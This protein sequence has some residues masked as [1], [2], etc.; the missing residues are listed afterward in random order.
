[1]IDFYEYYGEKSENQ[2]KVFHI[3]YRLVL[4]KDLKKGFVF[5]RQKHEVESSKFCARCLETS[6]PDYEKTIEPWAFFF[7]IFSF[8]SNPHESMRFCEVVDN[9]EDLATSFSKLVR[10][11]LA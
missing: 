8:S 9:E 7:N 3:V 2:R 1:M 10:R 11:L 4:A 6:K 5:K